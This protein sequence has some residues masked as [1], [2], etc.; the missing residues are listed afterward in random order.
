LQS[1]FG[2]ARIVVGKG[3]IISWHNMFGVGAPCEILFSD[4]QAVVAG[5]GLQGANANRGSYRVQ[6]QTK[7]GKNLS[8]ADNISDRQEAR[9]AAVTSVRSGDAGITYAALS[10]A[11]GERIQQLMT[12]N[13]GEEL[14]QHAIEHDAKARD[15][16]EQIIES[17]DRLGKIK[18]TERMDGLERRSE[19]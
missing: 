17:A 19:Y 9:W 14:L 8:L 13:Q 6:V 4:I 3:K 12:Q 1:A 11:A 7:D 15:R 18:L 5:M 2:S 16:F 10:D